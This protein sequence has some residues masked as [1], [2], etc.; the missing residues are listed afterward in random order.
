MTKG[1]RGTPLFDDS[2]SESDDEKDDWM[3][4][5]ACLF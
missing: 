1:E 5:A 4:R 2:E 3:P